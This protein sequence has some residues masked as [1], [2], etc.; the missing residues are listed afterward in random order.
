MFEC[1]SV[2]DDFF[3]FGDNTAARPVPT[4]HAHSLVHVPS[5]TSL[6]LYSHLPSLAPRVDVST[7]VVTYALLYSHLPSLAPSL[8][9]HHSVERP[10]MC[11]RVCALVDRRGRRAQCVLGLDQGPAS[12]CAALLRGFL[13]GLS[14]TLCSTTL[15]RSSC[16][17]ANAS[18]HTRPWRGAA[19]A[20]AKM[21]PPS[22]LPLV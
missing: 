22:L 9:T 18:R 19:G 4:R 20:L 13:R 8:E 17:M 14:R 5:H 1:S 6:L 10:R 21:A 12:G 16:V 2:R 3:L 15:A 11:L 7:R